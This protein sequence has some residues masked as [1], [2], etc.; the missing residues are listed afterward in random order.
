MMVYFGLKF[1]HVIGACVLLGTGGGIAF[2]M[3]AA[4]LT[5]KPAVVA[6]VSR[7]V[8]R[9]DFVFT[10][11]AVVLQ[12]ITG[13]GLVWSVGY[14]FY[15]YWIVLSLGLYVL[16]GLFWLPVVWMQIRM[17]DLAEDAVFNQTAL[18]ALYHQLFWTWFALGFPAFSAVLGI[19]W[20]MIVRPT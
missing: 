6:A 15:D 14:S 3:L 13:I 2:F 16:T 1:L 17:R 4:H 18:P 7:L 12:P 10:A 8:T 19:I 11:T 9:A 20:L 5:G